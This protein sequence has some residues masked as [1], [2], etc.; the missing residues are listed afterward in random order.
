M[1]QL[2][3]LWFIDCLLRVGSRPVN[4]T[5]QPATT[6]NFHGDII[7]VNERHLLWFWL[8]KASTCLLMCSSPESVSPR[9][10]WTFQ[11]L[12]VPW[13]P[14]GVPVRSSQ[15]LCNRTL[16][17]G[18]TESADLR[19]IRRTGRKKGSAP[20]CLGFTDTCCTRPTESVWIWQTD[21]PKTWLHRS[22]A[23]E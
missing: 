6:S 13:R 9:G 1:Q 2:I 19:Q 8:L 22:W 15:L 10:D 20:K 11:W 4:T 21:K 14:A 16:T 7:H 12:K 3:L 17:D 23:L 18:H 5:F